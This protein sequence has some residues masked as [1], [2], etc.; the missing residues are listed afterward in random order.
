[1]SFDIKK[2]SHE[3][4]GRGENLNW[5]YQAT[6]CYPH[7]DASEPVV[8][9]LKKHTSNYVTSR[10]IRSLFLNRNKHNN[11]SIHPTG[12][13]HPKIWWGQN[14]FAGP[15]SLEKT[16]QDNPA[17]ENPGLIAGFPCGIPPHLSLPSS[18]RSSRNK[19]S[20]QATGSLST[21]FNQILAGSTIVPIILSNFTF[22]ISYTM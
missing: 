21:Q 18:E 20:L 14:P 8:F 15:I 16:F 9:G 6:G 17:L 12:C 11:Y 5:L 3:T 4:G 22:H 1:M 2:Y 7:D 13:F 19:T 10:F